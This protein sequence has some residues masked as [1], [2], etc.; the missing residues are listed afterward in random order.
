M[1]RYP[2]PAAYAHV[3]TSHRR[4]LVDH[5]RK[6][7]VQRGAGARNTRVVVDIDAEFDTPAA[8]GPDFAEAYV[9]ADANARM[10]AQALVKVPAR[11]AALM[12]RVKGEGVAVSDAAVE[13]GMARETASRKLASA[14]QVARA[15]VDF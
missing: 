7:A 6:E 15:S 4:A 11:D 14:L 8:V 5:L 13:F 9:E 2:Q 1:R 12:R 10:L 3:R